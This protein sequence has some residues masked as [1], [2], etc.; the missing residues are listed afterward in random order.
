MKSSEES[1]IE[2]GPPD[3]KI[4]KKDEHIS[5]SAGITENQLDKICLACLGV[6]QENFIDKIIDE[7]RFFR[8]LSRVS[9]RLIW[10]GLSK[11]FNFY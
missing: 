4:L 6:L 8:Q 2:Y 1:D 9:E 3:S 10:H 5:D 11:F 7:V